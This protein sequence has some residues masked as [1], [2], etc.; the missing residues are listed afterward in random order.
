MHI[1]RVYTVPETQI[2][3]LLPLS[4]YSVPLHIWQEVYRLRILLLTWNLSAMAVRPT[5]RPAPQYIRHLAVMMSK[6]T[7]DER[8]R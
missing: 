8:R 1:Q 5:V 2:Q 3:S 6:A 4:V 7:T